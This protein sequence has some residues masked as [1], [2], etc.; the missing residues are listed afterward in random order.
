M[1]YITNSTAIIMVLSNGKNVRVEKTD[2]KYP[3]VLGIFALPENEQES[4]LESIFERE[5]DKIPTLKTLLKKGMEVDLENNKVFYDGKI[6]PQSLVTK[7]L[8]I[9]RDGL[10]IKHFEEF[11]K[12]L[13]K[14]PS[15]VAV[16]E[17]MDFL[18]YRE[19]PL[20][21]DGCF[22]AYKGVENNFW[23][24]QGNTET[25]VLQGEVDA[26][27]HI[28]NTVGSIIEVLRRDV[29]DDRAN[30]CSTGLHVG[31][32]DYA[33]G[34][35]NKVVVVKVDPADVVSV[36]KDCAFQKCRVCRY[37]VVDSYTQ[38][39]TASVV[40]SSGQDTLIQDCDDDWD[41]EVEEQ[42]AEWNTFKDKVSMYLNNKWIDGVSEVTLRQIQNSFSPNWASKE[43]VLAALQELGELFTQRD[44]VWV[45]RVS[46][47]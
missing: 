20:T 22:L 36:P 35:G 9:V 39:I 23:S 25:T 30:E 28:L 41:D 3:L 34:W 16:N 12:R 1:K 17:L 46:P 32:K 44:G 11:W 4:A 27:G 14:N 2:P 33:V 10:P 43:K 31:S 38:E 13:Q 47:N 15:S 21:E 40:D 45:V 8:S 19:L 37:E 6:L 26:Q 18:S 29:D 7:I 24:V 5:E 42:T